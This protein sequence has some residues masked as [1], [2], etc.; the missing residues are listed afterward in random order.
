[1]IH[2]TLLHFLLSD[3]FYFAYSRSFFYLYACGYSFV[4]FINVADNSHTSVADAVQ[5]FER[6]NY[7]IQTVAAEGAEA[8]IYKQCVGGEVV[9][10]ER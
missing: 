1:M 6:F 4:K 10:V 8:F 5:Y 7:C 3:N 9:A 2:T